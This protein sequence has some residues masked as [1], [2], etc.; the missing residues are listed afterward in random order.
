MM[1]EL[2]ISVVLTGALLTM[3]LQLLHWTRSQ[4]RGGDRRSI[5]LIECSNVLDKLTR[6]PWDELTSDQW[7]AP[8]LSAEAKA[9]LPDGQLHVTLH[10]LTT[11]EARR[12][13]VAIDWLGDH[14]TREGPVQLTAW[15]Y[16]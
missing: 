11:P 9:V 2:A 13:T 1:L 10:P 15:A 3:A 14:Q 4:R 7:H 6:L 5:A 8:E 12:I 16:P